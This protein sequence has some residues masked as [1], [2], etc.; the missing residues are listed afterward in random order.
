[1]ETVQSSVSG[2]P[3]VTV[4][5]IVVDKLEELLM[6]QYNQDFCENSSNDKEEMSIEE[7]KFMEIVMGSVQLNIVLAIF[8]L[9]FKT[10]QVQMPNNFSIAKQHVN[11]L[12]KRLLKDESFH[13]EYSTFLTNVIDKGYAEKVPEQQLERTDGKVWYLPHHGVY[14]PQKRNL[15]VV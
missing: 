8:K 7:G 10:P 1:M 13:K 12:K 14:H 4:N 15:R 3:A 9:P 11:S 2:Y 5:R 6:K